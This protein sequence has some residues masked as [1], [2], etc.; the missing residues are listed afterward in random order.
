MLL[1]FFLCLFISA[2][3]AKA[4]DRAG[5]FDHYVLSLSWN[6]AWCAREGDGREAPQCDARHDYDFTLHGLW[7]QGETDWPEYCRT[8]ERD[9]TRRE[10]DAMTPVMGSGGLAWHQ[11]KK[12][13]RCSGLSGVEYYDLSRRAYAEI[14]RPGI[15]RRLPPGIRLDPKVVE[16]AFLEANP[17]LSADGVTVTCR[18]GYL[19]EVR[20]CLT[21]EL[22]PRACAPAPA[23]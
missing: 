17:A 10:S 21:K 23:R 22:A 1:R 6:A 18:D 4:E 16:Q 20:I 2:M 8:A 13:G 5:D 19:Q 14:R 9:P 3:A 12:H 7:P 11:W 15:F